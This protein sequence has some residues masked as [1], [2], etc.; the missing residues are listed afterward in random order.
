MEFN[1]SKW[2]NYIFFFSFLIQVQVK[3][4]S[5]SRSDNDPHV[6]AIADRAHQDMMHHKEHQTIILSGESGSGKTYNFTQLVNQLCHI[7]CV[8][9]AAASVLFASIAESRDFD[10]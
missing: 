8:S 10:I 9:G 1:V 3:Y 7:G 6:F 4:K 2:K 5:K